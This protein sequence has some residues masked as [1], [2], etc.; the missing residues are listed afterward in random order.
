M[1][2]ACPK[3]QL[4]QLLVQGT[5]PEEEEDSA[6]TTRSGAWK[7]IAFTSALSHRGLLNPSKL[8]YDPRWQKA[9]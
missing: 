5:L 7:L 9:G 2:D 6:W 1:T 8:V 4:C 3:Q